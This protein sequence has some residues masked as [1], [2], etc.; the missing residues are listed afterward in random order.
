M[1]NYN[2]TEVNCP[3]CGKKA[4]RTYLKE[5]NIVEISCQKCDYLLVS[6]SDTGRVVEAY[7]P[8]IYLESVGKV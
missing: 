3:N 7:A 5:Q 8:G 2:R 1:T 6:C 4:Y